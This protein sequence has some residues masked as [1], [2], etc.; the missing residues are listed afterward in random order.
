MV[1][2]YFSLLKKSFRPDK[3]WAKIFVAETLFVILL[4][5]L[6]TFFL[7]LLEKIV[8]QLGEVNLNRLQLMSD[9]EIAQTNIVVIK[10]V[11][12]Q[13][14]S[15]VAISLLVSTC[16]SHNFDFQQASPA[17]I[18]ILLQISFLIS[19]FLFSTFSSLPNN[20]AMPS[21]KALCSL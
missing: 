4:Y 5:Y 15:F 16:V 2:K 12:T 19:S 21:A 10:S 9:L 18:G 1:K 3:R 11:F 14:Y 13:F 17:K 20:P 7:Q 6:G 8:R